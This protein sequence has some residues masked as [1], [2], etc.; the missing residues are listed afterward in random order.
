MNKATKQINRGG[1]IRATERLGLVHSDIWGP[2]CVT[3]PK[4]GRYFITFIDDYSCYTWV[5]VMKS[6][7]EIYSYFD[8]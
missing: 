5:Y 3:T 8:S 4:G 1:A 6:R 7:K 2:Y